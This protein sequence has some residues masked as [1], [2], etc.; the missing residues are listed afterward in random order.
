MVIR[1]KSSIHIDGFLLLL[2]AV[3]S[4][5]RFA[6]TQATLSVLSMG[7]SNGQISFNHLLLR[8][9][10]S[11]YIAFMTLRHYSLWDR[12]KGAMVVLIT[13]YVFSYSAVFVSFILAI[14]D[15]H[16]CYL[17]CLIDHL[18]DLLSR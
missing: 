2:M 6:T 8:S 13:I 9:I 10:E 3:Y 12:R 15:F 1:S 7:V 16:G 4:C 11:Q 5:K 18:T 17:S 14:K